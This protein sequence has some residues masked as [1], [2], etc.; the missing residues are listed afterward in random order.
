MTLLVVSTWFPLP[1]DNGS[2]LRAFHLLRGL[3]RRHDV[4]LLSF[5]DAGRPSD[6]QTAA[7]LECCRTVETVPRGA[8]RSGKLTHRGLLS[9]VPRAYAQAFS[10]EMD[11]RVRAA[12]RAHDAVVALQIP[13]AMCARRVARQVPSVF[14]E[15]EVAV[16]RDAAATAQGT[17]G[18]LRRTLTWLKYARFVR[19]LSSR[20]ACTTVVSDTERA[21]LEGIGCDSR[22]LKIVPNGVDGADLAWPPCPKTRGL[23][24]PGSITYAA[25]ADAV[26]WFLGS[27]LPL[28]DAGQASRVPFLVTGASDG[29]SA[30]DW[31]NVSRMTLT[32]R[33]PDVR[34]AI[35]ERAVCVVPLRVGGGTRLKILQAMALGT[36]VVATSKGAEG[37]DVHPERDILIGDTPERFSAQVLRVLEDP[38]LG[39]RLAAAARLLVSEQYT[40]ERSGERLNEAVSEA[41]STWKAAR[42]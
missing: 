32:G 29:V 5:C 14:E 6:E 24:Y 30:A 38:A 27:I 9:P 2:R 1:P 40:W 35:A 16:I 31:P 25:N 18:R 33:L 10:A 15:A 39:C 36:P 12:A 19:G 26:R 22:K 11:A 23:I 42:T 28:I 13:S 8:F 34:P 21:I 41:V 17:A 3:A 20:F 37:L 4:S 7:L